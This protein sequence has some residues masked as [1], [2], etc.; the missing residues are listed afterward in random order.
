[1]KS[2]IDA[3]I[4]LSAID[5]GA[6][7]LKLAQADVA[8]ILE[9]VA[10]KLSPTMTRRDQTLS[11]ELAEDTLRLR[12]RCRARRTNRFQP[13][14]KCHRIFAARQPVR[15][16]ARRSGDNIQIWVADT[17]RGIDPEFQK[18]AFERF[19]SKPLP[20]SHRGPGLGLSIV[21]SFT[22][23]HGGNVSLISKLD[24][25]QLL[26]V[27]SRLMDPRNKTPGTTKLNA[28]ARSVLP[29]PLHHDH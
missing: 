24:R 4:D 11:I 8:E 10:E 26:C 9:A 28:S 14:V 1:M 13:A 25:A 23:L 21:K 6:M 20:G 5:A 7:E 2:I 29:K 16:G 3:I 17:G 19:Q 27:A 15:I 18:K 12:G 22:E